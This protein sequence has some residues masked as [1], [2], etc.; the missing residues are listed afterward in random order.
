MLVIKSGMVFIPVSSIDLSEFESSSM[1]IPADIV[2]TGMRCMIYL[3]AHVV[4]TFFKG[5]QLSMSVCYLYGMCTW[6]PIQ[7]NFTVV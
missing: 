6:N 4:P 5:M 2:G 7:L 3:S 1:Y